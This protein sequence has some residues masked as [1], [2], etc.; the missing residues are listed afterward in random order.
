MDM[1]MAS[2]FSVDGAHSGKLSVTAACFTR[3][4]AGA[5]IG[6]FRFIG[7]FV[8]FHRRERL[9]WHLPLRNIDGNSSVA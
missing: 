6:E 1:L 8:T 2:A 4:V 9:C 7:M 3:F 5:S